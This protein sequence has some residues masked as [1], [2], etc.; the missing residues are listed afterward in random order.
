MGA[1]LKSTILARMVTATCVLGLLGATPATA[2]MDSGS[3]GDPT[4]NLIGQLRPET[5]DEYLERITDPVD[6]SDILLHPLMDEAVYNNAHNPPRTGEC[7]AV[8]AVVARGSEQNLR[9]RPTRYSEEAPWTSNGFEER[10]IRAMFSRLEQQHLAQTG[11]SLMKDVYVLGLTHIDYPAL[12]PLSD[13]GSTVVDFGSSLIQGRENVLRAI[14]RFEADTGCRSRYLLVGYS[15]GVLVV[16]GQ[17][18]ELIRRGQY[19][20]SVLIANP[21]LRTE[22]ATIIGHQPIEGGILSSLEEPVIIH[23]NTINYCLPGDFVCDRDGEQFSTSGSSMV[24]AQ[25]RTGDYRDGRIHSQYFVTRQHWD[26]Q[27]LAEIS[28]WIQDSE[29]EPPQEVIL[30]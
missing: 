23:P 9:I 3:S 30:P 10:T 2:A 20:G 21:S 1:R 5:E 13:E 18:E 8:T 14:D 24:S 28:R 4:P 19:V 12:L 11:G 22:D 29:P 16:D 27:V 15:Q 17:E 7:P 6:D 26:D 25:V